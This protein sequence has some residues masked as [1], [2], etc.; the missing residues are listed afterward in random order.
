ML[1]V[2]RPTPSHFGIYVTDLERMVSFYTEVFELT[3]TDRGEGK[4]FK[5]TLVFTSASADQHHQLVLASGRPAEATFST[6]IRLTG[7]PAL[8]SAA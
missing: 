8:F 4:T 5:K 3:I 1:K 2:S 7:W 6:V